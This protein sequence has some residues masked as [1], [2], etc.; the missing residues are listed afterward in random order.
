VPAGCAQLL[1]EYTFLSPKLA[2]G[3]L[4]FSTPLLKVHVIVL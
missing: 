1:N 4:F 3:S 2:E